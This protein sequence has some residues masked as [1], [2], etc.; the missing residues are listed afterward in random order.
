[1]SDQRDALSDPLPAHDPFVPRTPARLTHTIR[2]GARSPGRRLFSGLASGC[3]LILLLAQCIGSWPFAAPVVFASS[4]PK[5]VPGHLTLQ[6]FLHEGAGRRASAG[7]FS[8]SSKP[9]QV[10][11]AKG[12]HLANYAHLP[13]SAQPPTMKPLTITLSAAFLAGNAPPLDLTG[14]DHHLE[15]RLAP[16]SLD[17]SHAS[18]AGTGSGNTVSR[19]R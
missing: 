14:S 2:V 16:G 19:T 3:L 9:P 10:T 4:K 6:Q 11:L 13:P 15:V 18:V 12:E 5:A 1:M 8:F 17:L 7:S